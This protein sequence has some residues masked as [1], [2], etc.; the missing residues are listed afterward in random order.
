MTTSVVIVNCG[1][2]P[3]RAAVE[4]IG[5]SNPLS[6]SRSVYIINPSESRT[7]LVYDLQQLRI[8][9]GADDGRSAAVV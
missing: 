6:V 2:K 3:I 4:E 7:L 8:N 1:P 5:T 9:E